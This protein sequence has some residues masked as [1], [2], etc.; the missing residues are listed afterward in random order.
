M[1]QILLAKHKN[2]IN[3]YSYGGKA[4]MEI[5]E[6][7]ERLAKSQNNIERATLVD[8]IKKLE[9][10]KNKPEDL[11]KEVVPV[12]NASPIADRNTSSGNRR[13]VRGDI[14]LSDNSLLM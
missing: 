12:R 2:K 4:T 10:E 3:T 8:Q 9:K 11:P 5:K 7:K 6:L 1:N 13:R 14:M